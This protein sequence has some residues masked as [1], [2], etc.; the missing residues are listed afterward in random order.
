MYTDKILLALHFCRSLLCIFTTTE[1]LYLV[2][3]G[4]REKIIEEGCFSNTF[5]KPHFL[6]I[7]SYS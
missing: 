4:M 3:S 5:E 2:Q 7:Y 1:V 6:Y